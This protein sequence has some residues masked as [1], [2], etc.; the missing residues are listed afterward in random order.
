MPSHPGRPAFSNSFHSDAK[1][2]ITKPIISTRPTPLHRDSMVGLHPVRHLWP[3]GGVPRAAGGI[4]PAAVVGRNNRFR[5]RYELH[6][7]RG[8]AI[9]APR[10]D[11]APG[12]R[13]DPRRDRHD[14]DD[15]AGSVLVLGVGERQDRVEDEP[16][17]GE[18]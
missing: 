1:T 18:A 8:A 9:L 2:T 5:R 10:S 4:V 7:A 11:V 17:E 12:P 14:T 15:P 13:A 3:G 16:E 6:S